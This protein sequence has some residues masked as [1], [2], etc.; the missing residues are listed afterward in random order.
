MHVRRKM[1]ELTETNNQMKLVLVVTLITFAILQSALAVESLADRYDKLSC[2]VFQVT[3]GEDSQG[4]PLSSGTGF[5]IDPNGRMVTAAHVLLS[6]AI[7]RRP[8]KIILSDKTTIDIPATDNNLPDMG[9]LSQSDLV[10]VE[11]GHKTSCFI[12]IGSDESVA[13]GDHVISI[14]Y[15][16]SSE[17]AI[18]EGILSARQK[19]IAVGTD[20]IFLHLKVQL[21]ITVG[22]SGSPLITDDD[23]AVGVIVQVSFPVSDTMNRSLQ[24]DHKSQSAVFMDSFD[25]GR[26]LGDFLGAF[27]DYETSGTAFVVPISRLGSL[28]VE[29]HQNE[30]NP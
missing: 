30:R 1:W 13:V 4:A 26:T 24:G 18:Y 9:R 19:A 27:R 21:P 23:K 11:T 12:P 29:Q 5:F 22:A 20:N 15:S 7:L 6:G 17:A 28:G 25:I 3:A 2:A 14:G 8:Q 10:V 16:A